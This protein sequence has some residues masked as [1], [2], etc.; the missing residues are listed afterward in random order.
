V[1]RSKP[2]ADGL[3]F[4]P[5]TLLILALSLA[6]LCAAAASR[7][8]SPPAPDERFEEQVLM[9]RVNGVQADEMLVVLRDSQGGYWL[10]EQDFPR[11]RLLPPVARV[12]VQDGRRYL[13]LDAIPGATVYVDAAHALLDITLPADAFKRQQLLAPERKAGFPLSAS[14]GLFLNYE[15]Y[16]EHSRDEVFGSGVTEAGLFSRYGVLVSSSLFRSTDVTRGHVRLDTAFIRDFPERLETLTVGDTFSDPGSWGSA[17]R[18]GGLRYARN[19]GIRPD[20]VTLP[21]LGVSGSAVVPSTVDVFVNNQQVMSQQV[22]AGPF[23]IENLPPLTGAGDVNLVVRDALG[24]E[25]VLSQAFYS[26]PQLLAKGLT[27]FS[28][29]AGAVRENYTLSSFDYGPFLAS[30]S[31]RRGVTDAFSIEAHAEYLDGGAHAAGA[32]VAGLLGRLGVGTVT[33][34]AGGDDSDE[35]WLGGVGFER[36][37]VRGS[38]GFAAYYASD[39]F[40]RAADTEMAQFRMRFRGLAQAS[41]NFGAFGTTILAYARST[42]QDGGEDQTYSASYSM[43]L[44]G[45]ALNLSVSRVVGRVEQTTGYLTYTMALGRQSAPLSLETT[46]SAVD[47]EIEDH[48]DVRASLT[49]TAPVGEGHGWR[50]SATTEG[51]YDTWWLQRFSA[52]DLELRAASNFGESGQSALLRGGFSLLGGLFRPSRRIDSSFAVIDVAGIPDVPIFL[53]NQQVATTD[54]KGRA[55]LP[56]LLAYDI[57]R[58]S[59]EPKDLPLNT[60]IDSRQM[61]VRPAYRSGVVARFPVERTAPGTFNLIQVDGTPVPSGALVRFNG[62]EFRVA[63]DGLTYVTTLEKGSSGSAEWVDGEC[64]FEV[65][66]PPID[67]PL[68]D[69]GHIRCI[70][71]QAGVQ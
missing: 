17:L 1:G 69:M 10:E 33:L 9:L 51:D 12:H 19:F 60:S 41:W 65:D 61:E 59:I 68:P 11:L 49:R 15:L 63:L 21:L 4:L 26:S 40:R 32:E 36:H 8:A 24:R 23:S 47:S 57:N 55:L 46:A 13:P 64:R 5:R 38:V 30:A 56:S 71:T 35:G 45:G 27:Q 3:S 31:L 14:T 6:G 18:F 44:R 48:S 7:A 58:I 28:V 2:Q 70:G 22:E 20:L 42:Y 29:S 52:A 43:Q 66:S 16:A 39:G 67:D 25:V 37:S 54:A 62:G 34:A 53:E 50:A